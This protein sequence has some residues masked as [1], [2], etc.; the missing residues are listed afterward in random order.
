M[1]THCNSCGAPVEAKHQK[2]EKFCQWCVT[3][4]GTLADREGVKKGIAGWLKAWSPTE[5]DD[6]TALHRA[7]LYMKSMPAWAG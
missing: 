1:T 3:E 4:N 7:E 5:L 2:E 6:E